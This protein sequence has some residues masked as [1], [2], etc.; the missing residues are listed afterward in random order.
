MT[1][2]ISVIGLLRRVT[3]DWYYQIS[4]SPL[5]APLISSDV[6]RQ[7]TPELSWVTCTW[8]LRAFLEITA[9]FVIPSELEH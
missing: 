3:S 5:C 1:P 4:H 8:S 7:V 9:Y 2:I 6:S